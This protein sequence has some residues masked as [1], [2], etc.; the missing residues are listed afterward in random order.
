MEKRSRRGSFMFKNPKIQDFFDSEDVN[1]KID[2][3]NKMVMRQT[4]SEPCVKEDNIDEMVKVQRRYKPDMQEAIVKVPTSHDEKDNECK[5]RDSGHRRQFESGAVRDIQEG[6]GRCDLL[7]IDVL[8]KVTGYKPFYAIANFV[9]TGDR[10]Y[11]YVAIRYIIRERH[12]IVL[13]SHNVDLRELPKMAN[14]ML[15]VSLHFEV[16]AKKYGD[17]NWQ[18]GIPTKCFID[19]AVRHGLKYLR[20]DKDEP[21]YRAFIWNLMCCAWTCEH[22]PELNDFLKK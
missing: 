20:G 16:G 11:L 14:D 18:K 3:M 12:G 4:E 15:E 22:K 10:E 13:Q 2:I 17:N 19:S 7:P 6:K 1:K 9:N 5:I 21:H 8:A